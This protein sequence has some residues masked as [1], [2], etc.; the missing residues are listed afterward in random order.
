MHLESFIP[1]K[2]VNN[3]HEKCCLH[4]IYFYLLNYKHKYK[5]QGQDSGSEHCHLTVRR[6]MVQV[7]WM[8]VLN[9]L[10]FI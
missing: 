8:K 10:H 1:W 6:S 3:Q 9:I 5:Q 2:N 4:F 7:M